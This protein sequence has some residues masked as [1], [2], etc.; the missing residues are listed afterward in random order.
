MPF[1]RTKVRKDRLFALQLFALQLYSLSLGVI[2]RLLA[3]QKRARVRLIY[4]W[5]ELWSALISLVKF[6]SSN[7]ANL[8]KKMNVFSIALQVREN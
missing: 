2:H 5:K 6:I 7:E 4:P 8:V 3:Y 1:L